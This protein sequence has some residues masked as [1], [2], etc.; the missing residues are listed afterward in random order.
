MEDADLETEPLDEEKPGVVLRESSVL[1]TSVGVPAD[2]SP[3]LS[4]GWIRIPAGGI[5]T[6]IEPLVG[7]GDPTG[8]R[9]L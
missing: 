3:R 4:C 8:I 1:L 6:R 7:S 2:R 9:P 5:A